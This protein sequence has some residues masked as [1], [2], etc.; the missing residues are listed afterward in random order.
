MNENTM[1][2]C[3]WKVCRNRSNKFLPL[4][5]SAAQIINNI[6]DSS[7]IDFKII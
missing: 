3:R 4:A 2:E 6:I 5:N 1:L 7:P